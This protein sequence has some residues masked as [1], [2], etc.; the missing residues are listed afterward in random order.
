MGR[1]KKISIFTF[2]FVLLFLFQ[3]SFSVKDVQGKSDYT[4]DL[5]FGYR[6]ENINNS[7]VWP[8]YIMDDDNQKKIAYCYN[9]HDA[10]PLEPPMDEYGNYLFDDVRYQEAYDKYGYRYYKIPNVSAE[11]MNKYADYNNPNMKDDIL[12]VVYNGYP[13]DSSNIKEKYNLNNMQ[14]RAVTQCAIWKYTDNY[15]L[16]YCIPKLTTSSSVGTIFSWPEKLTHAYNF[17]VGSTGLTQY[18]ENFE[19]DLFIAQNQVENFTDAATIQNLLSVKM[20]DIPE[21]PVE[22]KIS[23]GVSKEWIGKASTSVTINLL[24]D[25]EKIKSQELNADNNWQYTFTDL[26]KTKDGK[27]IKY[28]ITEDS[29]NNYST[30]IT[31][32][33]TDGFIVTNTNIETISIPVEKIWIGTPSTQATINLMADGVKKESIVLNEGNSWK[34]TFTNLPKYNSTNGSEIVYTITENEIIGYSSN[35]T[36]DI[37]KG[38]VI[39]N[40][41]TERLSIPIEKRWVGEETNQ[42]T[43]N[44]M[45][46]G[47][48]EDS[49]VLNEDNQWKHTFT[50]LPKYHA[51]TGD[52]I[53][54]T[55]EEEHI[56]GYESNI[57]G[58][59]ASGFIITNTKTETI[60]T[61]NTKAMFENVKKEV[62]AKKELTIHDTVTL[63][64]LEIGRKYKLVGWQ[65]L[66]DKNSKLTVNGKDVSNEYIFIADAENMVVVVDFI[67]NGSKLGNIDL[68]TFEELYEFDN[69]DKP[70][71][72]AEHK[73]INDEGQT[74]TIKPIEKTVVKIPDT[75]DNANIFLWLSIFIVSFLAI[76]VVNKEIYKNK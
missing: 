32:N 34:H 47:V 5:Y 11:D 57:S 15:P 12:R 6:D 23:V 21:V 48:K 76:F 20:G 37:E 33:M 39:T 29:I 55:V 62:A 68:V 4:S 10:W 14:L 54:Y 75:D 2:I 28:T 24:A 26:D 58:D 64:G 35:I 63:K 74:V 40:V 71:K 65:M 56:N 41:N 52:E 17:L 19:L 9:V 49:I 38:F 8:L 72:V 69:S 59:V 44:L 61:I 42:V 18:P 45:A 3:I 60:I 51:T 31:G 67:F 36:G 66:K 70:Q 13:Y 22:E 7:F 43:V 16:E 30:K 53:L 1:F 27:T 50:D 46:D 73:D 25:G